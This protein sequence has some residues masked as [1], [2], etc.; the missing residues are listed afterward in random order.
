MTKIQWISSKYVNLWD[1]G[2]KRGWLVNGASAL[3]HL[4]R[5]SLKHSKRK[6][7]SAF[8]LDPT[9]L[10]DVGGDTHAGSAIEVLLDEGNR[11][12]RLYAD[13]TEVV[14]EEIKE[15]GSIRLESRK[16]TKWYTLEDRIEHMYNILEKLIDHQADV[17]RRS[18]LQINPRPRRQLEGWDFKDLMADGDPFFPRLDIVQEMGKGWI[19]FTRS[20]HAL[21]LFG[22]GFG[23]LIQPKQAVMNSCCNWSSL[24]KGKYYLAACI[25]DL[26][27]IIEDNGDSASNPVK[28][29]DNVLWSVKH[30]TFQPC[31]C[32]THS[33]SKH[34][35]PV[36]ALFPSNFKKKLRKK[37]QVD[38]KDRGAVIFGQNRNLHWH[39]KDSGPPER[40]DPSQDSDDP[41]ATSVDSGLGSSLG[42]SV[43]PIDS[44]SASSPSEPSES[45]E[46]SGRKRPLEA[47]M[48]RI[49]KKIK[50]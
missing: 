29:C 45:G 22:Q 12:L 35:D 49:S 30:A 50:R 4:V 23:E 14:E 28:L 31:P 34:H 21:C 41:L 17:E 2:D 37:T 1:V 7:G 46:S 32:T 16:T 13:K 33:N 40:G 25:R 42:S 24:P 15:N 18:G 6:L 48:S 47:M 8:Q 5:A 26:K 39:W 11:N 19:D 10:L 38:L 36:Q 43:S 3:L 9:H 44:R 20:I 27:E